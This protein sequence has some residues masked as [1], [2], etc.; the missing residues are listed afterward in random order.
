MSNIIGLQSISSEKNR[1]CLTTTYIFINGYV[2]LVDKYDE[3]DFYHLNI[4]LNGI[5]EKELITDKYQFTNETIATDE[6]ELRD[7]LNEIGMYKPIIRNCR[8][9]K[10]LVPT[11]DFDTGSITL[12]CQL[13]KN[14]NISKEDIKCESW[15][16]YKY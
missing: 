11:S 13:H 6:E 16:Y 7:M 9:C 15:V 2:V 12:K 10:E 14:T 3:I 1:D 8:T 4:Y 5:K